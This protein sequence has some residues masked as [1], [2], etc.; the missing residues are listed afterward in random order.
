MGG[1]GRAYSVLNLEEYYRGKYVNSSIL[2]IDLKYLSF[3]G[4]RAFSVYC[5]NPS[6][7]HDICQLYIIAF[8]DSD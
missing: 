2:A 3:S 8:F 5:M 4:G 6:I 7:F 1:D